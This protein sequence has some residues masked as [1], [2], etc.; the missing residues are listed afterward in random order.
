MPTVDTNLSVWKDIMAI[1]NEET[2]ACFNFALVKK[3]T[4]EELDVLILLYKDN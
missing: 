1:D 4:K 3:Y 2:V